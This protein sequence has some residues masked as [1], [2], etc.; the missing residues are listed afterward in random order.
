MADKVSRRNF[1]SLVGASTTGAV[2]FVACSGIPDEEFIVQAPVDLP[3]DLVKGRDNWFATT[4]GI[5]DGGEGLIVRVME[6]RAKKIAGN[7]DF[8]VNMGKQSVRCDSA[9]QMLYHPD[10]IAQPL[11][12][13]SK[14]SDL[15]PISWDEASAL[16]KG[17]V[18]GGSVTV[19]T[20]PLRGHLGK[21]AADFA[22]KFGGQH[23]QFD[24]L[25]QGVLHGAMKSVFGTDRLPE[26]DIANTQ[27][28]VSFGADFLGT[29]ISPTN[30]SVKYGEFRQGENR[31]NRGKLYQIESRMSITAA[32]A[33]HWI[34]IRPGMEGEM[35]MAIAN[36]IVGDNLVSDGNI[37]RYTANLPDGALE[38]F[39]LATVSGRTGVPEDTIHDLAQ[40]LAENGPGLVIGGGSAGA[41]TNGSFNLAAIYSLNIL[42]G[43]VG[44]EGGIFLNP[45]SPWDGV[46]SSATGASFEEWERELSQWRAGNVNT[47]ILRRADIIR[48]L[49]R[50]VNVQQAL[51]NVEHVVAFTDILDDTSALAD[52]VLPEASFLESWGTEI[53]EPAPGYQT[54]GIQQPV[55]TPARTRDGSRALSDARGFGDVLLDVADGDL[56]AS[57]MKNLVEKATT[58]LFD[59]DRSA[60][61]ITAP[62]SGLFMRGSL[63][64]GGW[65]DRE[66][67]VASRPQD[68]PPLTNTH[69]TPEFAEAA[70]GEG[71]VFYLQPFSSIALLDGRFASAPWAQSTPDPI[72]SAAWTTWAEINISTAKRLK[73]SRG[74]KLIIKSTTGEIE[75]LAYPHFAVPPD[76]I[77]I[78]IGQG[79]ENSGRWAEGRGANVL[80]IL[81]DKKDAVT[82]ALAWAATK[83]RVIRTGLNH[84]IARAE[85]TVDAFQVEPQF[86]IVV[87][88]P[89][90]SA[91]DA[92]HDAEA[93]HDP[94]RDPDDE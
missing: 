61:S 15:S 92:I 25:E 3:E 54:V 44:A 81:V 26:F 10:R 50:S 87:V 79:H 64:R 76:V 60:S 47:V 32:A 59:L 49:P 35:A 78:P 57:S 30:F 38:V 74:D 22:A 31:S 46:P 51:D 39:D 82:G 34:P 24:S 91:E 68:A 52:L 72:T 69:A 5:C 67:K 43:S 70:A 75:V 19:A 23:I 73:I 20:N 4:C 94:Y 80:S 16:L 84:E 12:R 63:Q 1:L 85:G 62:T 9:L 90:E 6:G 65:W 36:V 28:L 29:W 66:G 88:R 56:G 37:A 42:I 89:G 14:G 33:D 71:E 27:T 2:L 58:A 48:G 77:G 18:G 83:V 8:P 86:P 17:W 21:V 53:P 93:R 40:D 55:V 45:E 11:A 13:H 7:P 41:H